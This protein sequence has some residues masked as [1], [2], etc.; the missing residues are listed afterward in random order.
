MPSDLRFRTF[1]VDDVSTKRSPISPTSR[2][3]RQFEFLL[4]F[5]AER[6]DRCSS[7]LN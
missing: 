5:D 7:V 4:N 3:S 2:V 1:F 6:R